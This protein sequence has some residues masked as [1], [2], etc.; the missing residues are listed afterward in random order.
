MKKNDQ[1]EYTY[2]FGTVV[3]LKDKFRRKPFVAKIY[4]K[5]LKRQRSIGTARSEGAHV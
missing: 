1:P 5:T 3:E 4:D 2:G